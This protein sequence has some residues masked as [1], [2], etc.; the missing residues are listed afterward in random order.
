MGEKSYFVPYLWNLLNILDFTLGSLGKHQ[1]QSRRPKC[2]QR[3]IQKMS[4]ESLWDRNMLNYI[5][6]SLPSTR[7][8]TVWKAE[9]KW[10]TRQTLKILWESKSA[11]SLTPILLDPP[12][13]KITPCVWSTFRAIVFSNLPDITEIFLYTD[14]NFIPLSDCDRSQ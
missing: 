13:T 4:T 1:L 3:K 10:Q 14:C 6:V 7:S 12:F 11:H 5:Y 9:R 2:H 8:N